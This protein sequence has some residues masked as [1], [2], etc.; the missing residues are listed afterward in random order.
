MK[1]FR[2]ESDQDIKERPELLEVEIKLLEKV[3]WFID[4]RTEVLTS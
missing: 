4:S 1:N 3:K 2:G